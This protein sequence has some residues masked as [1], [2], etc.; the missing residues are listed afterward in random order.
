MSTRIF[1]ILINQGLEKIL[2]ALDGSEHS[3]KAAKYAIDI[4]SKYGS[5]IILVSVVPSKISHGDSSGVFGFVSG[6]Y[7]KQYTED[8]ETWFKEVINESMKQENFDSQKIKTKV[9]TTPVS[10][11]AAILDYAIKEKVKLIILGTRGRS[12]I[13]KMLLGS[14]A[15]GVVTYAHCPV[16]VIK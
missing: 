11:I 4:A 9:V 16:M 1:N 6:S 8:A 15:S 3:M 7:L 10:I 5:E 2:V 14:V 13:K 12:G